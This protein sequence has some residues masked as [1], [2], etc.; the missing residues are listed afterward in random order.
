MQSIL[1]IY[2]DTSVIGGCCDAEFAPWSCG[3]MKDFELGIYRPV[4]SDLVAEEVSKAP[5]RVLERYAELLDLSP[6]WADFTPEVDALARA[7]LREGVL[8]ES[9]LDDATHIALA[10]LADVD[11]LVSW[12]FR[13]IVRLDKIKVFHAVNVARGYS[14]IAIYSPREVTHYGPEDGPD[15]PQDSRRQL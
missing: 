4:L 15:G 1:R 7:Y 6:E 11:A 8:T 2:V 5:D 9:F 12:N 10:T 13:H 3:L 14:Q